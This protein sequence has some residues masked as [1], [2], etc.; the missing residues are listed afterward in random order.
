V[1]ASTGSARARRRRA[2]RDI[3]IYG[4]ASGLLIAGLIAALFAGLGLWLGLTARRK[5]AGA[6]VSE[7]P[8]PLG[9]PFVADEGRLTEL[10]IT[11]RDATVGSAAFLRK[12]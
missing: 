5:Q 8:G 9:G 4:L 6:I 11:P 7:A 3:V 2:A 12:R 10:G 1:A